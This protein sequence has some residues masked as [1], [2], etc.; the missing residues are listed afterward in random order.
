[1]NHTS[2]IIIDILFISRSPKLLI[3]LVMMSGAAI[4][5]GQETLIKNIHHIE[6]S[7]YTEGG[8]ALRKV[9]VDY[10]KCDG[11]AI[12]IKPGPLLGVANNTFGKLPW[13]IDERAFLVA[14]NLLMQSEYTS[15]VVEESDIAQCQT[16]LHANDIFHWSDF[17]TV[18]STEEYLD[19]LHSLVG[20]PVDTLHAMVWDKRFMGSV[21]LRDCSNLKVF[22]TE[23]DYIE[24]CYDKRLSPFSHILEWKSS[25]DMEVKEWH[26][27]DDGELRSFYKATGLNALDFIPSKADILIDLF[28]G[29]PSH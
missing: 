21:S 7:Y 5:W 26:A 15:F 19:W 29:I 1:M 13:I 28:Q 11:D 16:E 3:A 10:R 9:T 23:D 6:A 2:K 8:Y 27:V 12:G 18:Y 4:A 25:G 20:L 17:G 22:Y 24:L 14:F